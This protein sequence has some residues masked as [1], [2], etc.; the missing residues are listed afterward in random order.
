M[1]KFPIQFLW[2][3]CRNP[4]LLKSFA[5][6]AYRRYVQA[7]L[8][9]RREDGVSRSL[10]MI[11]PRITHR[12]NHRCAICAQWGESGYNARDDTPKVTGEVP[13]DVYKR[14][15]D[16][17]APLKVHFYI[18]G[19][20]PFLY[21]PLVPLVN[22]IKQ[23]GLTVQIV[24]NGVGLEKN[25]ETIV[26][27]GWDMICVS[28][29]GPREV[30][31]RC[32]GVQGAYDTAVK[33]IMK[34]QEIK[35]EK[36]KVKPQFFMIATISKTN[37]SMLVE[38]VREAEKLSPDGMVIY[39]SWFTREWIGENHTKIFQEKLG[40][41]PFAWKGYVRDTTNMDVD[42]IAEQVKVIK[43]GKFKMPILF[44][45][46]LKT[47]EIKKYYHEPENFFGYKNCVTPWF[48]LDIMPNGDIVTCRDFPDYIT[49][50]IKEQ[51]ILD[52]F[53]GERHRKFRQALRSCQN[54]VFPICSRCCGLMGF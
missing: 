28:L 4:S 44:V 18:T 37:E 19:G 33:G 53:N 47:D 32:R 30:H 34:I 11:S 15:V 14:V 54:G 2:P 21:Q 22:Y 43:S 26:E 40:V 41:T 51:S 38:T 3:V 36:K 1:R 12:C 6:G 8:D 13:L 23:K 24:T 29:D 49:G 5:R 25:A 16:E 9:Y 20:E 45:P 31:D 27:N 7:K 46:D 42:R 35:K 52:I 50:N 10:W 48:E 39:Y 17:V